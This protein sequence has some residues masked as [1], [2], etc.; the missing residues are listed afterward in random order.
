MGGGEGEGFPW[1]GAESAT[2]PWD[3]QDLGGGGTG[4]A[5]HARFA[6]IQIEVQPVGLSL[7][8]PAAAEQLE[9]AKLRHGGWV[10]GGSL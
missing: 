7:R 3:Q 4:P 5:D 10:W 6:R 2:G 8:A 9:P 1:R